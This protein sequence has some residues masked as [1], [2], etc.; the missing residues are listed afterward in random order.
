MRER[1]EVGRRP[2][3]GP[4]LL[5]VTFRQRRAGARA[6]RPR[7]SPG[8]F[9]P[10]S[11]RECSRHADREFE[12]VD[13]LAAQHVLADAARLDDEAERL[14]QRDGAGVPGEHIER[15]LAEAPRARGREHV[16]TE[17]ATDALALRRRH[18]REPGEQADVRVAGDGAPRSE[19]HGADELAL[20][21]GDEG[22]A[23]GVERRARRLDALGFQ[24]VTPNNPWWAR[25][26]VTF[27]DPDG[28]HFVLA[29]AQRPGVAIREAREADVPA[30]IA[31]HAG[32]WTEETTPTGAPPPPLDPARQTFVAELE[33]QLVGAVQLGPRSPIAS[34][35][36]VGLLA[37][38]AVTPAAQGK[39]VGRALSE[40]VLAAARARGF[41]KVALNVL[42][43]NTR[44]VAL[45]ESLGFVVEGR[46]VGE[47]VLC[48]EAVDSLELAIGVT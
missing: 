13:G 33:G 37:W 15:D 24:R 18:H 32:A 29:V 42:A 14:V 21:L 23:C 4:D 6:L 26:G 28:Y 46:R 41:R 9:A 3:E 10:T 16:L 7:P 35:A 31:L 39:G 19:L 5:G 43:R 36:H 22:L 48:G 20:E 12:Q 25:H 2:G 47:Y 1:G 38:L 45:Y 8:A 27:E 11:P 40:H 34:N 17:R 44:A 30:L